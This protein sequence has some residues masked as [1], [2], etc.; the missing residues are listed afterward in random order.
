MAMERRFNN[1]LISQIADSQYRCIEH[2]TY[3]NAHC[4]EDLQKGQCSVLLPVLYIQCE[5]CLRFS[6]ET[7]HHLTYHKADTGEWLKIDVICRCCGKIIR[8]II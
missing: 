8:K 5:I 4:V 2:Y 1:T 3:I 7:V 6:K